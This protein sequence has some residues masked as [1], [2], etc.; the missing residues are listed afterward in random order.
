MNTIML[1]CISCVILSFTGSSC[2]DT[3]VSNTAP[4]PPPSSNVSG[5]LL[6]TN[7]SGEFWTRNYIMIG[8][9]SESRR[10]ITGVTSFSSDPDSLC[11]ISGEKK[12]LEE[13]WF[14]K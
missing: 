14:F 9:T 4:D 8:S 12:C 10:S 3:E 11:I 6:A 1:I 5:I 2:V 7:N 13:K